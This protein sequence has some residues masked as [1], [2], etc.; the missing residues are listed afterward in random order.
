ML[1]FVPKEKLGAWVAG[2]GA[3][4]VFALVPNEKFVG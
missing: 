1:G 3:G 2:V 4:L